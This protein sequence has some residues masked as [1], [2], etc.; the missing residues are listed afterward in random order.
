MTN[1]AAVHLMLNVGGSFARHLAAAYFAADDNNRAKLV[2]AFP[3]IFTKY[4][5]AAQAI[6][7]VQEGA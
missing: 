2:A 6:S 3:E 7:A 4:E 1:L 5:Q